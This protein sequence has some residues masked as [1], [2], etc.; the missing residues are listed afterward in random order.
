VNAGRL[1]EIWRNLEPK[2]QVGLVGAGIAV[3]ATMFMLFTYSSRPS[4][5]T[6]ESNLSPSATGQ[7][8]KALASASIAYKI[9]DGG[10]SIQVQDSQASAARVALAAKNLLGDGHVGWE[11]YDKSSLGATDA[12]Q[13][14]QYQRA[15]EGEV[16]RTIEQIQG[17]SSA[18]VQLVLPEETLFADQGAQATAA[19]LIQ[20]TSLDPVTVAGIAHLVAS[21]VKGLNAQDVTITDASGTLLWPTGSAGGPNT[22]AKLQAEQTYTGQLS[23]Q[24]NTLLA[25]TLG[26]GKAQARVHADL[27]V[28][29]TTIDKTTYAKTGTALQ[30]TTGNESL[31]NKGGSAAAV[32]PSG[33]ASNIP[34]YAAG[35]AGGTSGGSNYTNKTGS[36]VYGVDKTVEHTNVVPGSVQRLSVALLIDKSVPAA[37]VA[38]IKTA[39]AGL[40]GIDP[41]RGDTLA[42]SSIKFA[43]APKVVPAVKPS[44]LSN[45]LGL[46]KYVALGLGAVLFLFFM[47]RGLKKRETEDLGAQPTWLRE[48]ETSVPL[49]Q[50]EAG[51]NLALAAVNDRRAQE[52]AEL[53]EIVRAQPQRIATQVGQWMKD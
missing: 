47:R 22:N 27:N 45:P 13:K 39:V 43:A 51:P 46:A 12:Q 44:P 48:I 50:L 28:D 3:I 34:T 31:L 35:A 24:I 25:S 41:K 5:V 49:S 9:G 7:A 19:V 1:Q 14:V 8:T 40:A 15:L 26:P 18:D 42:V 17:V 21:S 4:Y 23:A 20:S 29:Q 16:A 30:Q 10:T 36:T 11:I 33:A 37:Q 6:L 53:E 2:G 52:Q 32:A 38:S